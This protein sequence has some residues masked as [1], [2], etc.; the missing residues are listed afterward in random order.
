MSREKLKELLRRRSMK[1]GSVVLAAAL[2]FGGGMWVTREQPETVVPELTT[3]VDPIE[4]VVIEGEETPLGEP[5]ATKTTKTKTKKKKIKLKKKSKKTYTKKGKTTTKKKTTTQK[6]GKTITKTET[7]TETSIQYKFK[8]N[9]K[10]KTQITTTKT[11][12]ITTV[13]TEGE[14]TSSS[15]NKNVA[16]ATNPG[17]GKQIEN[18]MSKREKPFSAQNVDTRVMNA[19]NKLG[20]QVVTD[21]AAASA[22]GYTGKFDAEN[23]TITV[24]VSDGTVYH[25][26]GH[27]L[28]FVVGDYYKTS[29]FQS[30]YNEEKDLYGEY[31]KDYA[32]SNASEY[33][34]ESFC[35][36]V[37]DPGG[38]KSTRP[39]TYDAIADALS[40]VTDAQVDKVWAI[41]GATIWA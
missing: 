29:G 6:K 15:E 4:T 3:F 11:T 35:Q 16:G 10:I 25:E 27:F 30:V 7:I 2:V 9:S 21:A 12:T 38:L 36:Y 19:F 8:K 20:C 33:F 17:T 26:M 34:A 37:L 18:I 28:S 13:T 22:G 40:K 32:C 1:I 5:Q 23:Q 39:K 31:N 14:T 24:K 41:Y